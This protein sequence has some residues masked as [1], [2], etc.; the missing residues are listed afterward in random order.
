MGSKGFHTV[1]GYE[2][3]DKQNEALSHSME[4]YLE[5]IYRAIKKE[6]YVRINTLAEALNV[7]APSATRM[8]QKLGVLNLLRYEKYGI[9]RLTSQGEVIGKFLL[10]RHNT[11]EMFLTNMGVLENLLINVELIEHNLTSD[12]LSKIELLNRFFNDFPDILVRFQQYRLINEKI[13][14]TE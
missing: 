14:N 4:D 3:L 6:G 12:A 5:M 1:R 7:K 10:D 9:V 2:I 11:I 8:V 13:G